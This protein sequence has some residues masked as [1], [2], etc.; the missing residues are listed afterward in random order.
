MLGRQAR[1]PVDLC[2][3]DPGDLKNHGKNNKYIKDL[4]SRLKLASYTAEKLSNAI[5]LNRKPI[6]ILEQELLFCGREKVLV[7]MLSFE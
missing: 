5:K 4:R 3:E 6:M 1:L 2:F 7:K